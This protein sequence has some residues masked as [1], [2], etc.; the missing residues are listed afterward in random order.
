MIGARPGRRA[1]VDPVRVG[2]DPAV[3]AA[4][5]AQERGLDVGALFDVHAP[6]V[7]AFTHRM[8]GD[9]AEA[10]DATQ[11]TFLRAHRAADSFDGRCAPS[12]WLFAIAR[13]ACLDRL[14]DRDRRRRPSFA[15]LQSVISRA[16]AGAAVEAERRQYVAAVREGC[17]LA[18][19][20]CL[21]DDQ[22]AAFVLRTLC[23]LGTADVAAVLG[24]SENAVR[25]LL[26]RARRSLKGF[27][28]RN[29][30]VYDAAGPCRCENLVAFSLAQGWIGPGDRRVDPVR[31][32]DAADAAAV[33]VDDVGRLAAL[34]TTVP[35]R[36]RAG[37]DAD[38]AL[39][40][41]IRSRLRDLDRLAS[42]AET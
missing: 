6:R 20:S 11:E 42:A 22:R 13:N 23:D 33:A 1:R 5:S 8:L 35:G 36:G 24:R 17:L 16:E 21:T 18:T 31:A 41:R 19:L 2:E 34:Y 39:A 10:E 26:S 12:T 40:D 3:S 15:S 37:P 28:C 32:A 14:R 38:A 9:R 27:L 30:S 7:L 29:C 4:P 25:V